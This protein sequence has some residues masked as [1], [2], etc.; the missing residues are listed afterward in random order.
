MEQLKLPFEYKTHE[1]HFFGRVFVF[2]EGQPEEHIFR[3]RPWWYKVVWDGKA[4]NFYSPT[5]E[6]IRSASQFAY[7]PEHDWG[8]AF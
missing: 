8:V 2:I 5:P 3:C 7:N 4:Y 1:V 6:E